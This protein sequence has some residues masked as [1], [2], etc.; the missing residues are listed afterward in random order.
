MTIDE[1]DALLVY[2]ENRLLDLGSKAEDHWYY[3]GITE[4]YDDIYE[5]LSDLD[6]SI[7]EEDINAPRNIPKNI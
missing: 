5:L 7:P 3:G 2:L 4:I 6:S 1:K